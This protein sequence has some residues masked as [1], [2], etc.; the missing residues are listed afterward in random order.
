MDH[1]LDVLQ[2]ILD[3]YT[4]GENPIPGI[5]ASFQLGPEQE[6]ITLVSG[7]SR[8]PGEGVLPIPITPETTFEYCSITKT[9]TAALIVREKLRRRIDLEQN[10]YKWLPFLADSPRV[11]GYVT[12]RQLLQMS[13]GLDDIDS[14]LSPTMNYRKARDEELHRE[15][16][17][18]I[19]QLFENMG[20]SWFFYNEVMRGDTTELGMSHDVNSPYKTWS[21]MA[22]MD[23]LGRP[24]FKPGTRNRYTNSNFVILGMI[25]Q[26]LHNTL[27]QS[28]PYRRIAVENC[29][30]SVYTGSTVSGEEQLMFI[31]A[32]NDFVRC[33]DFDNFWLLMVLA[34]AL[35]RLDASAEPVL[36]AFCEDFSKQLLKGLELAARPILSADVS[37][38]KRRVF[39]FDLAS[40][41][42]NFKVGESP[43]DVLDKQHFYDL[44]LSTFCALQHLNPETGLDGLGMLRGLLTEA[45]NF[46]KADVYAIEIDESTLDAAQDVHIDPDG[47]PEAALMELLNWAMDNEPLVAYTRG[48]LEP[49]ASP[50]E[51][52]VKVA[53]ELAAL[54]EATEALGNSVNNLLKNKPPK[55]IP[56][57]KNLEER[58][59]DRGSF[60]SCYSAAGFLC[61]NTRDLAVWF[62]NLFSPNH[63]D[64][65]M[66]AVGREM[67]R[68]GPTDEDPYGNVYDLTEE[69]EIWAEG[70][71]NTG[72][73]LGMTR[74]E[75]I[76]ADG[77]TTFCY[78]HPGGSNGFTSVGIYWPEKDISFG[79]CCNQRTDDLF[80][81]QRDIMHKLD[82]LLPS[83]PYD[84]DDW[85]A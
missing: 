70:V 82:E 74:V 77:R 31:K 41:D 81:L 50:M 7:Y 39:R 59:R 68:E 32:S 67:R 53:E 15:K 60:M 65:E 57:G 76:M 47:G 21:P 36:V 14:S 3:A 20:M 27:D 48:K 79:M 71:K 23:Y 54:L 80:A 35:R 62:Y 56:H 38:G 28:F 72:Y 45:I 69:P 52:V 2:T 83:V 25:V 1:R 11:D 22:A 10:L 16:G 49:D 78:G 43:R 9:F 13:S 19:R 18:A 33:V 44:Y 84:K 29:M 37:S 34:G 4:S 51:A 40:F 12:V 63:G 5:S 30:N 8:L 64:P 42:L 66:G 17:R 26:N 75:V 55:A 58:T 24:L 85:H 61:G 73:G 6:P 46:L